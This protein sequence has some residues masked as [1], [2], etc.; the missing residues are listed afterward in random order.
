M[1]AESLYL[2]VKV[3]NQ[4]MRTKSKFKN[5]GEKNT[6]G[7]NTEDKNTED[8]GKEKVLDNTCNVSNSS[9]QTYETAFVPCET[10][11]KMQENVMYVGSSVISVC[12][13]LGLPSSLSKQKKLLKNSIMTASNVS[14]WTNEEDR[15]LKRINEYLDKLFMQIKPLEQQLHES[16]KSNI[17]LKKIVEV[18]TKE[19]DIAESSLHDI[20]NQMQSWKKL[21]EDQKILIDLNHIK[22]N[23]LEEENSKL[24]L[25][26][27][28]TSNDLDKHKSLVVAL[29]EN[30]IIVFS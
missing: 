16:Q 20:Q 12:E 8:Y 13:S 25:L 1:N 23:E 18:V 14:R 26:L 15:D 28:Q 19:K 21:S 17:D 5:T 9:T 3:K 30:E 7:K 27:K 29:G 22:I 10:C 24:N 2:E 4:E 11:A 6:G